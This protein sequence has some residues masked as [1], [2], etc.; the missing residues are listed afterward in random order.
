MK[1]PIQLSRILSL[2]LTG[3]IAG[4][5]FYGTFCVLPTF[6]EVSTETHFRFRTAL[7]NHNK[8]IVM[9]LVLIDVV[10]LTIYA[11]QARDAKMATLFVYSALFLTIISLVV[12]RLGSVPINL[13]IKTWNPSAPPADWM[14]TL[15]T[16]DLYNLARTMMSILSF[17]CL[18]LA[19]LWIVKYLQGKS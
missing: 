14:K 19:D 5:F 4:T 8:V 17:I 3:L 6:Y 1:S 16:W 9:A 11:W 7:M 2:L 13:I 12:T 10:V 15:A 18:L